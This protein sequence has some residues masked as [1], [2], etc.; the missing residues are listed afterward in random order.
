MFCHQCGGAVDRDD[1]FCARCGNAVHESTPTGPIA[2]LGAHTSESRRARSKAPL[3][4]AGL[5]LALVAGI[6]GGLYLARGSSGNSRRAAV[7]SGSRLAQPTSSTAAAPTPTSATPSATPTLSFAQIYSRQQSGVVRIDV[8]ACGD[9]QRVG[10]G[11]LLSPTLIATVAHVVTDSVVVSLRD[12][13]QHTTGSVIG[14]DPQADIALVRADQPLTGYHFA[15]DANG[16]VVGDQVAAVGF[17]IGDPITLTEGNVSGLDRA[18]DVEGF[19]R[20]G[21]IE[22]D[23]AVNPGNSGGPLMAADGSVIGLVDALNTEANGIAYAVPA[24]QASSAISDWEARPEPVAAAHCDNATGPS[25]DSGSLDSIPGLPADVSTGVTSALTTY[26]DGINSGDYASAYGVFSARLQAQTSEQALANGDADSF[27]Y[28]QTIISAHMATDG[29][30]RVALAFT[31]LQSA[32]QGPGGGGDTCDDW[33]LVYTMVDGGD[34]TW[35]ID[36][37]KPYNGSSYTSC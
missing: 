35:R 3:W 25:Q 34:G 13:S 30:A 5:V 14:I 20:T 7:A 8:L 29:S 37:T 28:G 9:S 1:L 26:F 10:T 27:D 32:S 21:L 12:G 11:F 24:T 22:T 16:P 15:F 6:G 4:A 17:P 23:A 31:S 33:T 36:S 2:Q 18:I 19:H